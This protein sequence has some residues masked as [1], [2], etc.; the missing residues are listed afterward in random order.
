VSLLT[1]PR[2]TSVKAA[3]G[4]AKVQTATAKARARAA[5][6]AAQA[7]K[8]KAGAVRARERAREAALQARPAAATAGMA[9]RTGMLRA[10]TGLLRARAWAAPHLERTGHTLEDQVA[11]KMAAMLSAAARRIEPPAPARIR[12]RWPLVAAGV[13]SAAGLSATAAFLL[14]RRSKGR[15]A[16]QESAPEAAAGTPGEAGTPAGSDVNGRVHTS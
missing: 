8:A 2:A 6:A 9:A 11:P 13:V 10:R 4:A 15:A 14:S 12:R 16:A 7:A 3:A 5:K 1:K